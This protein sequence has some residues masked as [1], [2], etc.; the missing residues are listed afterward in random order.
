MDRREK[1]LAYARRDWSALAQEKLRHW[2]AAT[3][4][5]RIRAADELRRFAAATHP[6]WPTPEDRRRDLAAHLELAERLRRA[7]SLR[8]R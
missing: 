6:G 4:A 3:P 8:R 1:L 5:E 2:R 7:T